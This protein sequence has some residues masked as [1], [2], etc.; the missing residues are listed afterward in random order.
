MTEQPSGNKLKR[1]ISDLENRDTK[2]LR[3]IALK[4]DIEKD[5]VPKI[6]AT[7]RG[8]IAEEILRVAEENNIPLYEDPSLANLLAKL[9]IDSDI[10]PELYT[11]IAEV[12]AF[13]YQLDTMAKKRTNLKK[14]LSKG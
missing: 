1:R 10:P 7:G 8:T 14:K 6:V 12:L 9:E 13:V 2:S 3:A 5:A 4:Y 11:L